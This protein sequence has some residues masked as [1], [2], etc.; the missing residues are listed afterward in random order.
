MVQPIS[1]RSWWI[2]CI[3]PAATLMLCKSR[4]LITGII[5]LYCCFDCIF[6]CVSVWVRFCV[7][8]LFFSLGL[9]AG[10]AVSS[11][12][13]HGRAWPGT[14]GLWSWPASRSPRDSW[15]QYV[16]PRTQTSV[17]ALR[18]TCYHQ[19]PY[20]GRHRG[21][22]WHLGELLSCP[23]PVTCWKYTNA[24]VWLFIIAQ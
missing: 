5:F 9:S 12:L 14:N 17:H 7:S 15:H 23:E 16:G 1:L 13:Y 3:S 10:W 6:V 18:T 11:A 8:D 4:F 20:V 19:G 21:A 24:R 2:H 22:L